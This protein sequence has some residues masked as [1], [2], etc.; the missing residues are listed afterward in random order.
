VEPESAQFEFRSALDVPCAD[1]ATAAEEEESTR[2]EELLSAVE[3]EAELLTAELSCMRAGTCSLDAPRLAGCQQ[4]HAHDDRKRR[5]RGAAPPGVDLLVT[6]TYRLRH[7]DV[8]ANHVP[9][10]SN[11]CGVILPL[12]N[13][14]TDRLASKQCGGY[15]NTIRRPFDCSSQII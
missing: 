14:G 8:T 2:D 10:T 7:R 12:R 3:R 4:A 5:R 11:T 13:W 1:T 6:M 9:G 15:S